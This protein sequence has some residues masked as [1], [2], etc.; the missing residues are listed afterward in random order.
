MQ[1]LGGKSRLVKRLLP[2]IEAELARPGVTA[3][4]EPFMGGGNV[5]CALRTPLPKFGSDAHPEL[6]ALWQ[7][8]QD[9]GDVPTDVD[10]AAYARAKAGEGPAW[11][12]GFIGFGGSF[13]GKWWG[14]Y[15]RGGAQRNYFS[16]ARNSLRKKLDGLRGVVLA[17]CSYAQVEAQHAVIYCDPPYVDTTGYSQ[18]TF[19]HYAFWQWAQQMAHH[20]IVLV[21]EY[22]APDGVPLLAEFPTHTEMRGSSTKVR[23][24]RTERLYRLGPLGWP[25][26]PQAPRSSHLTRPP[27]PIYTHNSEPAPTGATLERTGP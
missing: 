13:G 5:L 10:E 20:N 22:Q 4:V 2:Y 6:M 14:G 24:P 23:I 26:R 17:Q 7:H 8:L 11:L 27:S 21:S 16:N 3:Y 15:A 1:Y 9:G 12:R 18:G 19:S 25:P